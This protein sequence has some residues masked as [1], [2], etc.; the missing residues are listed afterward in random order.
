MFEAICHVFN[1]PPLKV[2]T[3][4]MDTLRALDAL[5]TEMLLSMEKPALKLVTTILSPEPEPEPVAPRRQ[6]WTREESPD[7]VM[8]DTA[9]SDLEVVSSSTKGKDRARLEDTDVSKDATS[10][11]VSQDSDT[12]GSK[13]ELPPSPDRSEASSKCSRVGKKTTATAPSDKGI[14]LSG[15]VFNEDS[16]VDAELVPKVKCQILVCI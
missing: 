14:D 5:P 10:R 6:I 13:R 1:I 12:W 16:V 9:E 15:Y 4:Y 11:E 7:V 3:D 2:V 8:V